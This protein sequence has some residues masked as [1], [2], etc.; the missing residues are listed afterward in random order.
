MAATDE[1]D[2]ILEDMRQ[3]QASQVASW[4]DLREEDDASEGEEPMGMER[5]GDGTTGPGTTAP[6]RSRRRNHPG[7]KPAAN[8]NKP[9]ANDNKPA[10]NDNKPAANNN[11]PAANDNK[12]A[13]NDNKPAANDNKPAANNNKPAA[14]DNKP[15]ANDNKPAAKS[16]KQQR[17]ER[18]D[19]LKQK[20]CCLPDFPSVKR[21]SES[22]TANDDATFFQRAHVLCT[23]GNSAEIKHAAGILAQLCASK[24]GSKQKYFSSEEATDWKKHHTEFWKDIPEHVANGNNKNRT[25][26]A[27]EKRTKLLTEYNTA[28]NAVA[29]NAAPPATEKGKSPAQKGNERKQIEDM[30][31]EEAKKLESKLTAKIKRLQETARIKRLQAAVGRLEARIKALQESEE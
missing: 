24:K 31:L 12:P 8:N 2:Q 25:E 20:G 14:N 11:K 27:S 19:A 10:A 18:L 3:L 23:N 1:L 15:A 17:E 30:E 7:A 28:L 26:K 21:V 5:S 4:A 9:A 29:K 22:P 13:A 6:P 16:K